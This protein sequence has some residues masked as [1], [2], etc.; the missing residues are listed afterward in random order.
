MNTAVMATD[1]VSPDDG[2]PGGFTRLAEGTHIQGRY[3]ITGVIGHGGFAVVYSAQHL[4]LHRE[5]AIKVLHL[6]S[7]TPAAL[8]ERFRL[9][10]RT[11]ALV[12]HANVLEVYDTG[13]LPDGSPY[14]VMERVN[15]LNL[16]QLLLEGPMSI[17]TSVEI[18][19]QLLCALSALADAGVVHRDVK[20]ANLMVYKERDGIPSV[21]LVDFGV[22]KR[23]TIEPQPRLTYAGALVGT[24]Q[25]MSPEQIRGEDVDA[26]ADIYA[27][28]AVLY[29]M[30]SGSAPH[31]RRSFSELVVAILE[32]PLQPLPELRPDCPTKLW[33][34]TAK[35]LSRAP[36]ERYRSARDMLAEVHALIDELQLPNGQAVQAEALL[37]RKQG[38]EDEP[39]PRKSWKLRALPIKL[40][41]PLPLTVS[42]LLAAGLIAALT[43]RVQEASVARS[44][45][46]ADAASIMGSLNAG[47]ADERAYSDE[48]PTER[49]ADRLSDLSWTAAVSPAPAQTSPPDDRD[50][51]AAKPLD[52][53]PRVARKSVVVPAPRA[54][55]VIGGATPVEAPTV[56]PNVTPV[57]P[58]SAEVDRESHAR[59]QRAMSAA[60]SNMIRGQLKPAQMHYAQAAATLPNSPDAFRGL[61]LVSARLGE[62]QEARSA[63]TRYL[64]LSPRAE[65]ASAIR[66]RLASLH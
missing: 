66:A 12:R 52:E 8:V 43:S 29:E 33:E 18:L 58:R 55:G 48:L 9:E 49:G 47:L 20:P 19:R 65:D 40:R 27:A 13:S 16:S 25:Y 11:S 39:S 2:S 36:N 1:H 28:G 15:G 35:A 26:R 30:L 57:F 10:A 42:A 53:R 46:R 38:L 34:I 14:I 17:A 60:L 61:G 31:E 44:A 7:E 22:S 63:L 37:R 21:K 32:G 64:E 45:Q 62:A 41:G 23:V 3:A 51:V 4:G 6:G 5:V 50:V 54:A 56:A 24:P 59:W